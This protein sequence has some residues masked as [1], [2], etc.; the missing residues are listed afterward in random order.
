MFFMKDL[1]L[2]TALNHLGYFCKHFFKFPEKNENIMRQLRSVRIGKNRALCLE[3]W[4]KTSGT[5]ISNKDL[6]AVE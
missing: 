3:R 5:V 2:I 1:A 6:P 4:S